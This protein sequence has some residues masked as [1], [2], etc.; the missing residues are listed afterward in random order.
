MH[1]SNE[2]CGTLGIE[3]VDQLVGG[4]Q[5]LFELQLNYLLTFRHF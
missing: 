4:K 2:S 5:I 1:V 3:L